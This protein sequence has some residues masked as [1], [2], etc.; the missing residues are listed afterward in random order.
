MAGGVIWIISVVTVVEKPH[1]FL[2]RRGRI[3]AGRETI[4]GPVRNL[5]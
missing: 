1:P 2:I 4:D 5:C 3:A